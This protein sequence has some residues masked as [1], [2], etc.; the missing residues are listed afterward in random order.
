MVFIGIPILYNK[1]VIVLKILL[2]DTK[3]MKTMKN[4]SLLL[5]LLLILSG[6]QTTGKTVQYRTSSGYMA[7]SL[8]YGPDDKNSNDIVFIFMHGKGSRP[9]TPHATSFCE[10]LAGNNHQVIAPEMPWSENW[11]G[12]PDD[13]IKLI[14]KLTSALAKKNKKVVLVGHSLGGANAFIYGAGN[15]NSNVIGIVSVAPG[16]L[17]H[18][19]WKIKRVASNSVTKAQ[20]MMNSGKG[21]AKG[22]FKGWNN[23]EYKDYHMAARIYLSYYD[24]K[25]F[26]NVIQLLPDIKTP[27]LW[28]AGKSDRLTSIYNMKSLFTK[29]SDN[30]KNKYLEIQGSHLGVLPNSVNHLVDW[31]EQLP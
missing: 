26:P 18:D 5:I 4:A 17:L 29:L 23:G 16:H 1:D 14:D 24:T 30:P 28:V 9:G 22:D 19:S 3:E 11:Y 15:P 2:T 6:C 13:G 27:V 10:H 21:D 20:N 12:T 8:T 31:A 25:Q 7:D